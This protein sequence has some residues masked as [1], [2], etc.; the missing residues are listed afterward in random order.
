MAVRLKRMSA[1]EEL[2]QRCIARGDVTPN[3]I[4]FDWGLAGPDGAWYTL[5][6][7]KGDDVMTAKRWLRNTQDV[8]SFHV[9]RRGK[10]QV[11]SVPP[12][13]T[14]VLSGDLIRQWE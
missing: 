8:V 1:N 4:P 7:R 14:S 13:S 12:E 3:G 5:F 9:E 10:T 6:P 11:R 2:V